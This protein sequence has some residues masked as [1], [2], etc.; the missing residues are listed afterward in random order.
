MGRNELSVEIKGLNGELDHIFGA[1]KELAK[2][3]RIENRIE[4]VKLLHDSGQMSDLKFKEM[5][6]VLWL[7][8]PV[9]RYPA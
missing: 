1:L 5:L 4:I 7:N 9:P 6:E 2:Q 3:K 8:D